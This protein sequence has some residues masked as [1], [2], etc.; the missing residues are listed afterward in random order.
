MSLPARLAIPRVENLIDGY[1]AGGFADL[2]RGAGPVA[3]LVAAERSEAVSYW[4]PPRSK[5]LCCEGP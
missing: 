5:G 4:S 3:R 2:S 1:F